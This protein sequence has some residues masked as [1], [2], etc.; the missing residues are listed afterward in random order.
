MQVQRLVSLPPDHQRDVVT[1]AL[2]A[3]LRHGNVVSLEWSQV[4]LPRKVAWIYGDQAKGERDNRVRRDAYIAPAV[5]ADH[6]KVIDTKMA[7]SD[8]C[9][10]DETVPN[11]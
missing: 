9:G 5:L 10:S 3:G 8:V 4:D 2:A 6:A 1:F 11:P 7:Q